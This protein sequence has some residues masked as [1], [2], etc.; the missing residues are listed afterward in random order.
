MSERIIGSHARVVVSGNDL[1]NRSRIVRDEIT[2]SRVALPAFICN[3]IWR[4]ESVPTTF[5]ADDLG[6]ELEFAPPPSGITIRLV[7]FPPDSEV[8]QEAY[9]AS[10]DALH[11]AALNAGNEQAVGM[12]GMTTVDIDTV[13]Q[14]ELYCIFESGEEVLLRQGDSIVNRGTV[15]GW[16]N[17]TNAPTT[18][19]AT[20]LAT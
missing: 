12:H 15:H 9:G 7:T 1:E 8:N 16:S 14:G 2:T 3:D 13:I 10:I 11:G 19:V 4:A 17:R 6:P 20:I 5:E 18:V